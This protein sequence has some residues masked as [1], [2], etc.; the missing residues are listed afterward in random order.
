[1]THLVF[2]ILAIIFSVL[3]NGLFLK[4]A[5][6]LGFKNNKDDTVIRWGNTSKPAFGGISFYIVFLMS[7]AIYAIVLADQKIPTSFLGVLIACSIGFL[8]GLADDA[9]NTKPLLKFLG[10]FSCAIILILTGNSINIFEMDILNWI[11]TSFWVVGIMNSINMLDNMDAI[12]TSVTIS[13]LFC[14]LCILIIVN[15]TNSLYMWIL[16]GTIGA[17]FGFLY[18]N[19]NPSKMYMGD[20]GSQFIGA[21]ISAIG[22]CFFW[23]G[24]YFISNETIAPKIL[25]PI[26]VFLPT[27][28]D[29]TIVTINRISKG[30]S[31]FIGGK[32]HTTHHLSYLGLNDRRVALVF[33]ALSITC[34]TI[35]LYI[36][37]GISS[38]SNLVTG[39]VISFCIIIFGLLFAI[40]KKKKIS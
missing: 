26:L 36:N 22:I 6:T 31:P 27:I 1:M 30:Q 32:D 34:L 21:L 3:I 33:F 38:W 25:T 39:L 4:F 9:Y 28:V 17:L 12:T 35:A 15:D 2:F 11:C 16:T 8:V 18:Y 29:T 19:W 24:T 20:T 23:N 13:I 40:T 5:K 7:F 14:A 37:Y 10:Q